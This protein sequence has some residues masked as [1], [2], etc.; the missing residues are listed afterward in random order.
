MTLTKRSTTEL[1]PTVEHSAEAPTFIAV[2]GKSMRNTNE[3]ERR[4][5]S[6]ILRQPA[7]EFKL[8]FPAFGLAG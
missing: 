8:G 1:T 2:D 6:T 7:F 5:V 4:N 3:S